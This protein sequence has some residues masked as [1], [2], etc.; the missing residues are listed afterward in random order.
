MAQLKAYVL[1]AHRCQDDSG[2]EFTALAVGEPNAGAVLRVA[3]AVTAFGPG[4]NASG[5]VEDEVTLTLLSQRPMM[6]QDSE[7]EMQDRVSAF[8]TAVDDAVDHGL[9]P[10]CTKMMQYIVFR[11]HLDVIRR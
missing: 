6:F 10:G 3:M 8:E 2:M 1:K 5:D 9:P 7:V 11:T 4:G